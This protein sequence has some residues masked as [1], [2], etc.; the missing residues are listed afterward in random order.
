[1]KQPVQGADDEV[2]AYACSVH[3][4]GLPYMEFRDRIREG[5]RH[6]IFK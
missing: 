6:R 1:M 3:M 5:D 2:H 4:L